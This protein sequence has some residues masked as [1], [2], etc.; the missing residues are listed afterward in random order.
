MAF[1]EN[2]ELFFADFGSDGT[3]AG[4]PVRVIFSA[5]GTVAFD[6][7]S[8][9]VPQAAIATESV[10]AAVFEAELIIPQGRYKVREHLPDGTGISTLLLGAVA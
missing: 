3:L 2:L 9:V 8:A 6:G 4:A 1:V 7:L 10:P 5:A